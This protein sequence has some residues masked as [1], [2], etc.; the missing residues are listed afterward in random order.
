MIPVISVIVIVT[1]LDK[2]SRRRFTIVEIIWFVTLSIYLVISCV[3]SPSATPARPIMSGFFIAADI[4][5]IFAPASSICDSVAEKGWKCRFLFST[6]WSS[7]ISFFCVA[8]DMSISQKFPTIFD[9]VYGLLFMDTR[10]MDSA[11]NLSFKLIP[12][13]TLCSESVVAFRVEISFFSSSN[14]LSVYICCTY[15]L[16]SRSPC[17]DNSTPSRQLCIA[18]TD[19]I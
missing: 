14:P 8:R 5:L 12:T 7:F 19:F 10:P 4:T 13:V 15:S 3:V 6:S 1:Y 16:R 2:V 11:S 17:A 9:L 18:S